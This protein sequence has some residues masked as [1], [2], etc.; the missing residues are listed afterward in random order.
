MIHGMTTYT[1]TVHGA[2]TDE[3]LELGGL[4]E[5]EARQHVARS[6]EY[7]L[8]ATVEPALPVK[9]ETYTL[10]AGTG[11]KIRRAT[12]VVLPD[13]RVISF[14]ERLSRREALRQAAQVADEV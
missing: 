14:T 7:R 13:G 12:R 11:R 10:R 3:T 6:A 1:V 4:T 9:V 5:A 8:E 2:T